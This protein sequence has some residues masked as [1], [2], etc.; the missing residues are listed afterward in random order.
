VKE[1]F[2]FIDFS[3]KEIWLNTIRF[4]YEDKTCNSCN[5]SN[6]FWRNYMVERNKA[7]A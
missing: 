3:E 6:S 7:W 2:K 5:I 1:I 4:I